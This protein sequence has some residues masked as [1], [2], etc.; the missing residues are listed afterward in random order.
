MSRLLFVPQYPSKLRYQEWWLDEFVKYFKEYFD[1]VVVLGSSYLIH[2][3]HERSKEEMFSPIDYAIEFEMVQLNHYMNLDSRP[4]DILFIADISFPGLFCNVFYHKT[5]PKMFAFCHATSRNRY[6]YFQPVRKFKSKQ[7]DLHASFFDKIFFG[8]IYSHRKTNWTNGKV[9][10]LPA[11]PKDLIYKM[12]GE[13]QFPISSVCRPSIQ[14][15]NKR[16]E[17]YVEKKTG[18]KIYRQ[19][20]ET[21]RDYSWLLTCSDILLITTK[22]DTFNYTIIDAIRC[23]CIPVAPN[24]MCFPEILPRDYLY[25]NEEELVEIINHILTMPYKERMIPILKC[26]SNVDNF[27]ENI[28]EE[29]KK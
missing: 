7:E 23:G 12:H 29:M 17:K 5:S 18:I 15:V 22:E 26:Q 4:D 20:V 11:P 24:T 1:E 10:A 28:C 13:K 19:D 25:N 14:K 9:V 8:S 27:F 6:D 16:I 2:G 21:W 3:R